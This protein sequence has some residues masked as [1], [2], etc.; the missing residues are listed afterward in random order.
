MLYLDSPI[1]LIKGLVIYRDHQD[2]SLFY[3]RRH[4][5]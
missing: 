2:Q 1:G 4:F 5:A 3:S